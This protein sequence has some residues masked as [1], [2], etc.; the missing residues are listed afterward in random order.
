[1]TGEKNCEKKPPNG[2]EYRINKCE[3]Y[4]KQLE[5]GV[6]RCFDHKLTERP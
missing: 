4:I 5:L 1:L 2:Y 3:L 6:I